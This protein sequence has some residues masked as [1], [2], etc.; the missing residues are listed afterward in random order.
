M[1][2]G[3]DEAIPPGAQRLGRRAGSNLAS[4]L[5][6]PDD[7]RSPALVHRLVV[8]PLLFIPWLVLYESVVYR[9]PAP[10]AFETYLPGEIRWPIWQWMELLYVSPYVLVTL[11]P[12]LATTNRVLRRFVVAGLIATAI[13]LTIFITVPAFAPPRPFQPTGLLGQLMLLDRFVDR[14]N[15][16]AAFPSFHVV[17]SFLGAAVFAKRWPKSAPAWWAWASAVSA[18]CV[19]TGMH[20]LA[21]VVAGFVVFLATYHYVAA[22]TW[23]TQRR[24]ATPRSTLAS[25]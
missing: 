14:N 17:W 22:V 18:S 20:S 1:E 10:G 13:V 3:I 8:F 4:A 19:L 11:A 6:A 21:D 2:R 24:V 16:A 15:G 25:R 7:D 12:L 23:L 5:V 9:G